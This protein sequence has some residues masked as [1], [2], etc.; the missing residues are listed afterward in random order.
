M[1]SKK[2]LL[3]VVVTAFAIITTTPFAA[4]GN[5]QQV[6]GTWFGTGSNACLVA[7]PGAGF[8]ANLTPTG[9]VSFQTSSSQITLNINADGTGT[10]TFDELVLAPLTPVISSSYPPASGV[11]ASSAT[12]TFSFTYTI[13]DDGTLTVTFTSLDGQ[14]LTGPSAGFV[15]TLVRAGGI[16]GPPPLTGRISR[17]GKTVLLSSATPEDNATALS[18]AEETVQVKNGPSFQRICYRTRVFVSVHTDGD[19]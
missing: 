10:G 12:G 1:K 9:G 8:N 3:F 15:F 7:A 16:G 18:A 17:D 11:S 19:N 14:L 2:L 13:A 4:Q 6:Q 5:R